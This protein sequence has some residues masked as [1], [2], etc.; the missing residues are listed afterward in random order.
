MSAEDSSDPCNYSFGRRMLN[1]VCIDTLAN[2]YVPQADPDNSLYNEIV[3]S[4]V[5]INNETCIQL[6]LYGC[7]CI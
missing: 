5:V 1:D 6:W 2:N 4:Q 3:A 7:E